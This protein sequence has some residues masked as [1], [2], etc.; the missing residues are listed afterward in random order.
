MKSTINIY[1]NTEHDQKA[2]QRHIQVSNSGRPLILTQSL[3]RTC[4]GTWY[5]LIESGDDERICGITSENA[6]KWAKNCLPVYRLREFFP[7]EMEMLEN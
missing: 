7:E 1:C 5:L 4:G 2:G 6:W 3:Y